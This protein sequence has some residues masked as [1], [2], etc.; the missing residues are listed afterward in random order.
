MD[1]ELLRACEA[2]SLNIGGA[3]A[4]KPLLEKLLGPSFEYVGRATAD[5]LARYGNIN[6]QSIFRRTA[7][8]R[9]EH[10]AS[11]VN[12]RVL[13]V[14][15]EEGAFAEDEVAQLYFAGLLATAMGSPD[16]EDALTFLSIVK[17]LSASQI[18]MHDTYYSTK[19]SCHLCYSVEPEIDRELFI[20]YDFLPYA[21]PSRR[22]LRHVALGLS[23]EGLIEPEYDLSAH[24]Y[25]PALD[26]D[27]DGIIMKGTNLGAELFLW[28]HGCREGHANLLCFDEIELT[29]WQATP[30]QYLPALLCYDL[31]VQRQACELYAAALSACEIAT[32]DGNITNA[33]LSLDAL[34]QCGAALPK[35]LLD[36]ATRGA[37]ELDKASAPYFLGELW[38]Y[39]RNFGIQARYYGGA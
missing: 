19:R 27:Y 11:V 16:G 15:I 37:A 32:A 25:I 20:T 23:R 2:L 34:C 14:V 36:L 21:D 1:S 39:S 38:H 4:A 29:S 18:R 17:N 5:L 6:L 3:L 24:H 22:W 13:K 30:A 33:R 26:E 28:V 12:P 10:A 8:L 31:D 9:T 7:E 35:N